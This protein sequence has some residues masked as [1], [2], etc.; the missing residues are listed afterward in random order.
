MDEDDDYLRIDGKTLYRSD[1]VA[2]CG[3]DGALV[4]PNGVTALIASNRAFFVRFDGVIF[5][6]R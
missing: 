2:K 6:E 1:M 3:T 4:M 5:V